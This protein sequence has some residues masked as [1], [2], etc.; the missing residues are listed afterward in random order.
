[1]KGSND[2]DGVDRHPDDSQWNVPDASVRQLLLL[3]GGICVKMFEGE[4]SLV[5]AQETSLTR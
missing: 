1:M 4:R 2:K 3:G 5:H